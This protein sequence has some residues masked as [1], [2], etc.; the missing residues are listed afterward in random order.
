[1][2]GLGSVVEKFAGLTINGFGDVKDVRMCCCD[3]GHQVV[4]PFIGGFHE[5]G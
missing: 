5:R 4:H 2:E 1:M 3:G